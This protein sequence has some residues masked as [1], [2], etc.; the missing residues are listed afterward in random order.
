V[1]D[2]STKQKPADKLK[3]GRA[4]ALADLP[5]EKLQAFVER[6]EAEKEAR[7]QRLVDEGK[8]M[9]IPALWFFHDEIKGA[10][11]ARARMQHVAALQGKIAIF[12]TFPIEYVGSGMSRRPKGYGDD[13]IDFGVPKERYPPSRSRTPEVASAGVLSTREGPP[14]QPVRIEHDGGIVEGWFTLSSD[15]I[16][17][18][19]NMFGS[20]EHGEDL[21]HR[22]SASN[23]DPDRIA[24][25]L[26]RRKVVGRDD[27]FSREMHYPRTVTP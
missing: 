3:A 5:P 23:D 16:V 12:E 4:D 24:K 21:R 6:L 25:I 13:N 14:P 15:N 20:P 7:I 2:S 8:A 19:T 11:E 9:R 18:L 10:A 26:L 27:G 1:P 17:Q 22:I